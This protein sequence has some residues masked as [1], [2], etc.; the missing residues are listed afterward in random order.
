MDPRIADLK[1]TTISGCRL[2]R[3]QIAEPLVRG[4]PQMRHYAD[5]VS[6][7]LLLNVAC[8]EFVVPI[9]GHRAVNEVEEV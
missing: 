6:R 2:T 1:S 4:G 8:D 5:S 7:I 9:S 3:R